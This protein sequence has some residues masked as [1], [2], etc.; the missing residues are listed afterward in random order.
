MLESTV[1]CFE[2]GAFYLDDKGWL[3][4][5]YRLSAEVLRQNN[6]KTYAEAMSDVVAGLDIYGL[7]DAASEES[8]TTL[9]TPLLRGLETLRNLRPPETILLVRDALARLQERTSDRTLAAQYGLSG[10]LQDVRAL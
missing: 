10:W 2:T 3:E 6:P 4:E 7:D 1:E 8:Y 9:V 5:N